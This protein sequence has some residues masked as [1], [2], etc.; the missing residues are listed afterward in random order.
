[1]FFIKSIKYSI[2]VLT[3]DLLGKTNQE[4]DCLCLGEKQQQNEQDT[5]LIQTSKPSLE[6]ASSKTAT[7]PNLSRVVPVMGPKYSNI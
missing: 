7:L 4:G 1:M 5:E 3:R 6:H 2:I